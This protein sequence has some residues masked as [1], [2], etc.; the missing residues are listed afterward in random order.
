MHRKNDVIIYKFAKSSFT[1]R[2]QL[3]SQICDVPHSLTLI[4]CVHEPKTS[5]CTMVKW[6]DSVQNVCGSELKQ[7]KKLADTDSLC[8]SNNYWFWKTCQGKKKKNQS[9]FKKGS[10]LLNKKKKSVIII[11]QF[12][13]LLYT[14]SEVS[15]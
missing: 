13:I 12:Y 1:N 6:R 2:F 5:S 14:R 7:V 8:L 15:S 9:K 11:M 10:I 4:Q 3:S